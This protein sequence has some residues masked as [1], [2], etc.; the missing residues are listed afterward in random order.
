MSTVLSSIKY[1]FILSITNLIGLVSICIGSY[2]LLAEGTSESANLI[3]GNDREWIISN[4]DKITRIY[5]EE[6][7]MLGIVPIFAGYIFMKIGHV[8]I[9]IRLNNVEPSDSSKTSGMGEHNF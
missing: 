8:F 7:N 2:L 6:A 5:K 1:G 3:T 4:Q 9:K